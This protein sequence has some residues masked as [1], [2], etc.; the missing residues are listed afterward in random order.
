MMAGV[1]YFTWIKKNFFFTVFTWLIPF[2][3]IIPEETF[4]ILILYVCLFY[5]VNYIVNILWKNLYLASFPLLFSPY[6]S[7]L[8]IGEWNINS[9]I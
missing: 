4:R 8:T 6:Q 5:Y 3:I 7:I 1:K 9:K 2:R